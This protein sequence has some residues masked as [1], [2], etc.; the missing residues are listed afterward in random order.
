[1]EQIFFTTIITCCSYNK[2]TYKQSNRTRVN[3]FKTK[4]NRRKKGTVG[5]IYFIDRNCIHCFQE[6]SNY[7][8]ILEIFE[9][10]RININFSRQTYQYVKVF[11]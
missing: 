9:C 6:T 2:H 1:M 3:N 4:G 10:T 7:L 5:G 8:Y 11:H